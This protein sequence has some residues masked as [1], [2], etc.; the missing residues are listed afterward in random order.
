MRLRIGH[1][2]HTHKHPVDKSEPESCTTCGSEI[3]V[4]RLLVECQFNEE[5]TK[6]KTA[7][8]QMLQQ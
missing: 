5:R 6:Y 2:W 7:S 8:P 4:K 3:S 1:T